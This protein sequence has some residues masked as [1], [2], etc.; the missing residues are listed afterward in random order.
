MVSIVKDLRKKFGGARDQNDRPTCLAFAASDC[1]SFALGNKDFLSVE[2]VYFKAI[3]HDPNR[4]AHSGT[5]LLPMSKALESD[6]QPIE[7]DWPYLVSLPADLAKWLPPKK[8]GKV[9]CRKLSKLKATADDVCGHLDSDR[10]ALLVIAISERFHQSP[11]D[12][13]IRFDKKDRDTG[14]HAVVAVGHAKSATGRLILIRNSWGDAW[15]DKGHAWLEE[16]YLDN[17]LRQAAA[18]N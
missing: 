8:V 14:L 16:E 12:A 17:R 10:P 11:A 2:Y 9:Y 5:K 3:K 15:C 18:I 7:T 1:H 13:I 4:N 6:G